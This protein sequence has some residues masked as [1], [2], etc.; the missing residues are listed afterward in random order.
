M[1][2]KSYRDLE[3]WQ[4]AVDLVVACYEITKE[5]P[6]N[7]TYGLTS[8]LQRAAASIPTNIAEGQ[9]RQYAKEF[10][11]YLSISYGSI[12]EL[13]TLMQIAEKLNYLNTEQLT[14]LLDRTAT[15]GRMINGLRKS[16]EKRRVNIGGIK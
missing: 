1:N 2:I 14:R 8:Q 16:L 5:F 6:K 11:Q 7:E 10:I 3:V 12:D 4:K 13:E 9:A 15:L